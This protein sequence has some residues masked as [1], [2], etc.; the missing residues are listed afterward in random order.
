MITMTETRLDFDN[1][2]GRMMTLLEIVVMLITMM[3][4]LTITMMTIL[5]ITMITVMTS[6][7]LAITLSQTEK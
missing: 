1:S 2:F 4:I 6:E 3:T 7:G 5:M